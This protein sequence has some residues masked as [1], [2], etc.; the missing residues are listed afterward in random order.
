VQNGSDPVLNAQRVEH[1]GRA[2]SGLSRDH[3]DLRYSLRTW[4]A[5]AAWNQGQIF[6]VS[7]SAPDWLDLD[8]P[9]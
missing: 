5:N 2:V 7:P 1:G 4:A 8:H 3:D 9:R 6:I